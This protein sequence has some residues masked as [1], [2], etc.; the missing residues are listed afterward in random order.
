MVIRDRNTEALRQNGKVFWLISSI[1]TIAK[2]I[3][4][5]DQ[6]PSLTGEKSFIEEIG[7]VLAQRLP[8]YKATAHHTIETDTKTIEGVAEQIISI[9]E[10]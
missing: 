4:A 10:I 9:L 3:G 2:R 5:D 1:D 8:L 7:E 6:R